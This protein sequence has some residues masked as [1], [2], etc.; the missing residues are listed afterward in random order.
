MEL[1][2]LCLHLIDQQSNFQSECYVTDILNSE[3]IV[4]T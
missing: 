2:D 1:M 3:E 4:F